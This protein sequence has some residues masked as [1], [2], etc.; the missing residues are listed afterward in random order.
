MSA[1]I[2]ISIIVYLNIKRKGSGIILK[3]LINNIRARWKLKLLSR[4]YI[5]D[6]AVT[7]LFMIFINKQWKCISTSIH[8]I[9]IITVDDEVISFRIGIKYS[10]WASSGFVKTKRGVNYWNESMPSVYA[11][12]LMLKRLDDSLVY[13]VDDKVLHNKEL[14]MLPESKSKDEL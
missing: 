4:L 3:S 7:N 8:D 14:I 12:Y 10:S 2:I 9:I 5:E 11:M 6:N 13:I 1:Y